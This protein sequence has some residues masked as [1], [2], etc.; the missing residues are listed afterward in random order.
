LAPEVVEST[1]KLLGKINLVRWDTVII[2]EVMDL[3]I[4]QGG[5]A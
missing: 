5:T 4:K 1:L 2:R 3:M